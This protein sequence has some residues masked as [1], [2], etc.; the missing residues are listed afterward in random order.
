MGR[1]PESPYFQ[2]LGD[3]LASMDAIRL[4]LAASGLSAAPTSRVLRELEFA[5][6]ND[7][8]VVAW[9]C[10]R[11]LTLRG[12]PPAARRPL[13]LRY[14]ATPSLTGDRIAYDLEWIAAQYPHHA[15]FFARW[16]QF[17]SP[18]QFQSTLG[19][20]TF[21]A[22]C[23]ADP[24]PKLL[25]GL[26]LTVQQ[27]RECH[28]LKAQRWRLAHGRL[29]H[30]ENEVHEALRARHWS[31]LY[32]LRS[33]PCTLSEHDEAI[34]KRRLEVWFLGNLS[35]WRPT[36]TARWYS[37]LHG[38]EPGFNPATRQRVANWMQDVERDLPADLARPK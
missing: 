6:L 32:R 25:R 16:K 9:L 12:L 18:H 20:I 1:I 5:L 10:N 27:Q 34:L 22:L 8:R 31:R 24:V 21:R 37:A 14:P 30:L 13:T 17:T 19:K 11:E 4:N 23:E 26:A 7:R 38:G 2:K 28:F 29:V 3:V 15:A 35:G 33:C 36:T